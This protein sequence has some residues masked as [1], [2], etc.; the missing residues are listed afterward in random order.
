MTGKMENLISEIIRKECE[1][2]RLVEWGLL[3]SVEEETDI[4]C[5]LLSL[6][7]D[8]TWEDRE[9]FKQWRKEL[10]TLFIQGWIMRV[11]FRNKKIWNRFNVFCFYEKADG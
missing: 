11:F 2:Y 6:P 8:E 5:S 9:R 3:S 7:A 10:L 1:R 4:L